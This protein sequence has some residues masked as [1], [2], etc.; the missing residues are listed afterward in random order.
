MCIKQISTKKNKTPG[1][2]LLVQIILC[3]LIIVSIFTEEN[4][5]FTDDLNQAKQVRLDAEVVSM[6]E[7]VSN[8]IIRID[9]QRETAKERAVELIE[10]YLG[11]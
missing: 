8:T 1:R 9:E 4:I 2:F 10:T 3:I 6:K 7:I 11:Q 5:I